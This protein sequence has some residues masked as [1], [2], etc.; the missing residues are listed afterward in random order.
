[1][2]KLLVIDFWDDAQSQ[3]Y[4]GE[5]FHNNERKYWYHVINILEDS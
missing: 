2:R 1:L 5:Y 3:D 4:I